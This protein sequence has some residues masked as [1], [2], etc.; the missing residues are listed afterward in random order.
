[1]ERDVF[2]YRAYLAQVSRAA[3]F[4]GCRDGG[5]AQ[6]ASDWES[7]PLTAALAA[8]TSHLILKALLQLRGTR[9]LPLKCLLGS[10][11]DPRA[12]CEDE[13]HTRGL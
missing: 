9:H 6:T 12:S 7:D 1:M 3:S 11:M 8:A 2:L 4:P 13:G 5:G 10:P